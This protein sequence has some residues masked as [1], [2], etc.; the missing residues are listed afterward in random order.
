MISPWLW[1]S[2]GLVVAALEMVASGVYLLWIGLGAITVAIVLWTMPLLGLEGQLVA[3]AVGSVIWAFVGQVV[4]RRMGSDTDRPKLNRRAEQL[5]GREA[6]LQTPIAYGEGH[7][8]LD[9]TT[10]R[11][12]GPDLPAGTPVRIVAADAATLTVVPLHGT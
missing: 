8:R 5:V 2:A 9:D 12:R 11:V 1:L 3:F 4:Y 7:I 10:W 6:V